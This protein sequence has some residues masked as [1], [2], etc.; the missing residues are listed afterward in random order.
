MEVDR[1]EEFE[2]TF[3]STALPTTLLPLILGLK[4]NT[5]LVKMAP[6]E[7]T[8]RVYVLAYLKL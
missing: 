7:S 6:F 4:T 1:V 3:N 5:L 8:S 2:Q